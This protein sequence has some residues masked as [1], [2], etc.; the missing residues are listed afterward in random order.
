MIKYFYDENL[1]IP[2]WQEAFGD[3]TED[4]VFFLRHCKHKKALGYFENN[5]LSSMLFLVDCKLNEKNAEY[6]YAA[7]TYK[8]ERNKGLMNKL[9][10]FCEKEYNYLAL[11]A[12]N[13]KLVKYYD[14]CNFVF[15][16]EL[17]D[18]KFDEC[19]DIKEYLFE[20]CTLDKPILS[21]Y[22]NKEEQ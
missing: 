2:L 4:I 10:S 19:D 11:L 9:L 12:A 8:C 21:I 5:K 20:G 16:G 15:R 18:I 3:S 7:C 14:K 1:I 17:G 22:N 6:I 13:E